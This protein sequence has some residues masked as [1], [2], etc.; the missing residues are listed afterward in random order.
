MN[1]E[2]ERRAVAFIRTIGNRCTTCLRRSS[3]NC[4][5]CISAWANSI[6]RDIENETKPEIDYSLQARMMMIMDC[7][8]KAGRPLLSAEID[9]KNQCTRQL[10]RWTLMRLVKAGKVKRVK[11]NKNYRYSLV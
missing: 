6:L 10:K 4:R 1:P 2:T 11:R 5:G 8:C 9:L 3:E 7:L